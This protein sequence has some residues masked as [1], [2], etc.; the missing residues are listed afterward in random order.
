MTGNTTN[1]MPDTTTRE[2]IL[3]IRGVLQRAKN[4]AYY[5]RYGGA[6]D[7]LTLATEALEALGRI[8]KELIARQMKLL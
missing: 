8:E 2:D 3:K 7:K 4:Y 6:W 1:E 5:N